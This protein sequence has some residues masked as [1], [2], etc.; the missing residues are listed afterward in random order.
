MSSAKL[1]IKRVYDSAVANVCIN[2]GITEQVFHSSKISQVFSLEMCH[3]N[4]SRI[5]G[6]GHFKNLRSLCI[7]A[8]DITD[9]VGLEELEGLEQLWICETKIEEIKGLDNLSQLIKLFL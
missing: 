6:L 7:V 1:P 3:F 5:A 9:I 8:Q 2:N 4:F